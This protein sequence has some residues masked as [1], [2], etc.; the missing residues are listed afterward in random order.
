MVIKTD[1]IDTQTFPENLHY[2]KS[3]DKNKKYSQLFQSRTSYAL[4]RQRKD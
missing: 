4:R 3:N 1:F 2:E